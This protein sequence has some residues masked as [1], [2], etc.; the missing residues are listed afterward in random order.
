MQMNTVQLDH[1]QRMLAAYGFGLFPLPGYREHR[2]GPWRLVRHLPSL[3]DG[4]VSPPVMEPGRHV[5]YHRR[6]PWMSTGLL[7][8]ESHAYHVHMAKGAVV[9]AGLGLAMYLH[10]VATRACVERVVVIENSPDVIALMRIAS[11]WETWPDRGKIVIL[12]ADARDP[13][14]GDHVRAALDGRTPDYLFADIWPRCGQPDAPVEMAGMV[15]TFRP[16]HA[17]WWGQE[18]ALAAWAM[19][20]RNG[21]GEGLTSPVD[22]GPAEVTMASLAAFFAEAGVPVPLTPGYTA[23]CRDV[24]AMN[25]LAPRPATSPM[26]R[27]WRRM[28]GAVGR[29]GRDR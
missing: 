5:L 23:F 21:G 24:V 3:A 1:H 12:E 22:A 27:L 7:E 9:V 10:A 13:A 8:R 26:R 19:E 14:L 17:G 18:L 11:A 4:Y 15:R 16:V 20:L 25:S 2:L 29:P 6:T 28:S